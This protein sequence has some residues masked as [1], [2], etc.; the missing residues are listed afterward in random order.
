MQLDRLF[1]YEQMTK[2]LSYDEGKLQS[3]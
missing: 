3:F 2:W 1:P